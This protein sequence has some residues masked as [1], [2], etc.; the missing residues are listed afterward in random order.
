M[1]GNVVS[2]EKYVFATDYDDFIATVSKSSLGWDWSPNYGVK[3]PYNRYQVDVFGQLTDESRGKIEE[4]FEEV[5]KRKR[6]A[7][8]NENI[9]NDVDEDDIMRALQ[10]GYGD[11]LGY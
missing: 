9:N 5:E 1:R 11:T 7:W 2:T 4:A 3:S 8:W 6:I 10:N